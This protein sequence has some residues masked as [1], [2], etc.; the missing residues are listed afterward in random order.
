MGERTGR[1]KVREL[2]GWDKDSLID[3]AEIVH[4]SKANQG[5]HSLLPIGRQLF[6][7][8]QEITCNRVLGR[9]MPSLQMSSPSFFFP[10]LYTL[11]MTSCGTEYPCGHL[12][13]AVPAVPPP[14]SFCTPSLLT[15][16]VGWEAEQALTLCKHCSA[17]TKSSLYYQHCFQ[18][19]SKT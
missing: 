1:V 15:G 16:G 17:A 11:S 14:H 19:K 9:Q 10:P 6:S 13:S 7:H 18:H 4:E 2:V 5:V 12:G 3:T 8:L